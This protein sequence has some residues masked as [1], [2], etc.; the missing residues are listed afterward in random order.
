MS[1]RQTQPATKWLGVYLLIIGL[2][3]VGFYSWME[4]A[5]EG[6]G[7]LYV[8]PRFYS[9]MFL[10]GRMGEESVFVLGVGIGIWLALLGSLFIVGRRPLLLY[11]ISEIFMSFLGLPTLAIYLVA[12]IAGGGHAIPD[13]FSQ[14]PLLIV[15]FIVS[16]IPLFWAVHIWRVRGV[17]REPAQPAVP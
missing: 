6:E 8:D 2:Y 1:L 9:D 12:G 14:F 10:F 11:I 16:S 13:L 3:H 17:P 5:G 7:S 15:F 4:T